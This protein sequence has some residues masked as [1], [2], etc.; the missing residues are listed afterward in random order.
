MLVTEDK[1]TVWESPILLLSVVLGIYTVFFMRRPLAM[2][3]KGQWGC[4]KAP[5]GPFPLWK[6][7]LSSLDQLPSWWCILNQKSSI[8]QQAVCEHLQR[9]LTACITYCLCC[10]WHFGK[11]SPFL[12]QFNAFVYALCQHLFLSILFFLHCHCVLVIVLSPGYSCF[13]YFVHPSAAL[14]DC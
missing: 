13:F 8:K 14:S 9:R 2:F 3:M 11:A 10:Q 1:H 6:F 12:F 7:L 5:Q 4:G